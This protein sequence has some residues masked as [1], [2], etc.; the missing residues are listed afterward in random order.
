MSESSVLRYL[1]L[2]QT[3]GDVL[4]K[5]QRHG[6]LPS[7][8]DFEELTVLQT[9]L[10]KPGLYLREVQQELYDVT[11]S[12][13][14]CS[15]LCRTAK[16]LGLSR[17][18]MKL[19]AIQRSDVRRAEY[20]SEILEFKPEML[21]FI[22]ETVSDRRNA[23]RKFGY[24]LRGL[25]PVSHRLCLGGKRISA[26]GVLTTRGV[27]D[28]YIVEGNVN[29]DVFLQFIERSLLPILPPFDG[30]N[31]RSVV[32]LDN[33]SI[34]HVERVIDLFSAAGVLVRFLPPYSPDLN[35]IEEAFSKVKS[36][37]KDNEVPYQSTTQPWLL[38]AEAFTNVTQE[39]CLQ[40]MSHAG[41]M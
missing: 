11:S 23:I 28:S 14:D 12:W 4:A 24:G 27:E 3:T 17:Q 40:Y 38:V 6:P 32:V 10:D 8:S 1:H 25:T 37:L 7:L 30:D 22:D 35:P 21:V 5:N 18:K 20:L 13:Y 33:A 39:N 2:F 15:T 19:V 9:L 26:I 31:P 41:Y 36:Y 16:R 29:A 34:H